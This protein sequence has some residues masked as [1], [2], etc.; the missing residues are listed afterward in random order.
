MSP[1]IQAQYAAEVWR[2][3]K[4]KFFYRLWMTKDGFHFVLSAF[5]H[6][7]NQSKCDSGFLVCCFVLFY[8]PTLFSN[9]IEW[10]NHPHESVLKHFLL[11]IKPLM[12]SYI[13]FIPFPSPVPGNH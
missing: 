13:Q 6:F 3:A 4:R 5:L 8:N 1:I 12:P 7:S 10:Y 2:K 11:P 9:F